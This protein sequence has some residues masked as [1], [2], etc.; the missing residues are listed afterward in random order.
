MVTISTPIA[1][2]KL[3]SLTEFLQLPENDGIFELV[4]G[5]V[6][7]KVS[8]K[9]FHA[10]LAIT[11]GT[12]LSEWA[13]GRGEL[14]VEWAVILKKGDRDWVPVPDL[15]YLSYER[16]GDRP[17]GNEACPIPPDLVVEIL[18]PGQSFG[19]IVQKAT[20]YL[21]AGVG[22]VWIVEPEAQSLTVFA[23]DGL[24]QTYRDDTPIADPT[25]PDLTW[26]VRSLFQRAGLPH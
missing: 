17:L 21:K 24:P 12:L 9:F 5:E 22:R 20:D 26:T 1:A 8:P 18:S 16:L 19:A 25:L 11:L 3:L 10:K 15:T 7:R 23:A 2:P 13:T 6:I 14:G 4:D